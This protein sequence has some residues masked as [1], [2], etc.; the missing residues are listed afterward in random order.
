MIKL[1]NLNKN[2]KTSYND[3]S[4]VTNVPCETKKT[5][6]NLLENRN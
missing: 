1:E 4:L 3:D 5:S 6:K 2:L